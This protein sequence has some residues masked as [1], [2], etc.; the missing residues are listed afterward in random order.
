MESNSL[1]GA[2]PRPEA[3][4]HEY[5]PPA[6]GHPAGVEGKGWTRNE[7]AARVAKELHNGQYGNV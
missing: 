1:P 6:V 3:V 4:R 5:R 2:P 7:L